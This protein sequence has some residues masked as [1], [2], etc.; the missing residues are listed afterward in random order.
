MKSKIIA[1]ANQK[2]GVGKTTT[3]VS[4][5][6]G[7]AAEG[8]RILLVDSDPQ[9]NA[10]GSLGI[11]KRELE[12]SLY[13][14]L[15]GESTATQAILAS[16]RERLELLPASVE[17]AGAE[18][19]LTSLTDDERAFRLKMALE[20]VRSRFD[21]I[22]IDC[23]PS[24]GQI[25][26]NALTA[27]DGVIIPIQCEYL[28][29]EGLTQLKNTIDLVTA[30]LNP[31]LTI[32]GIIMTMYDGRTNL[33]LQVVEEVKKYFPEQIFNTVVPRSVRL[34]EAPSF[35]QSIFEYDPNSRG[36][37]AYKILTREMVARIK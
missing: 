30:A 34:S 23:P 22:L 31:R 32:F 20:P 26:V 16:G 4:L 24:L 1:I 17:L 28:A 33:A 35:G 15:V 12:V 25:T 19:E 13:E 36:A 14:V 9:G 8:Y 29:L 18:V 5:S 3:A 37:Q 11:N 2:G 21:Y 7:L 27:A 6:A 10:T